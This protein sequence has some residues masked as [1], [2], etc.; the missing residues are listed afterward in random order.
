MSPRFAIISDLHLGVH[1]NS[2][3]WH[4]IAIDYATWL[5]TKLKEQDIANIM[6]CGDWFHHRDEI[7][8]TTIDVSSKILEILKDYDI[9][10]IPGNHDCF[11]KDNAEI[12]SLSIFKGHKNI[13]IYDKLTTFTRWGKVISLVPWGVPITN[14]PDSDV[15]FGH[16][17]LVNFKMNNFKICDHGEDHRDLLKKSRMTFTGHFHLNQEST[18]ENGKIIY[19]GNP[20][21]MDFGD[22]ER[23][24]L[25]YI[26]DISTNQYTTI[27]NDISPKHHVM[28]LSDLIEYDGLTDDVKRLFC[29]NVV[30]LF[31]DKHIS[32]DE[33]TFLSK[34]LTQLQPL[35]FSVEYEVNHDKINFGVDRS[36]EFNS[37]DVA[38]VI[39][40]FI[41]LLEIE[42]KN[43]VSKYVN[44]LYKTCLN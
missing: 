1:Q 44:N 19:T 38:S 39:D 16:F 11:L 18:F 20:F 14:I 27:T 4:K 9:T 40:E 35:N 6:F 22:A 31:V 12:N 36:K 32:P 28:K 5:N 23:N 42:N 34:K 30:K 3:S 29:G 15:V 2:T 41:N 21:Q 43:E 8:V 10:M 33:L 13:T 25:V 37:I 17:E 24:K 7:S 26:Y